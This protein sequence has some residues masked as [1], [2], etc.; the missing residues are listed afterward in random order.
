MPATKAPPKI[1][2]TATINGEQTEFLVEPRQSVAMAAH[3]RL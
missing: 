2:V 3:A 1:H